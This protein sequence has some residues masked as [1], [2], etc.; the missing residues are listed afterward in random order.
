VVFL[1]SATDPATYRDDVSALLSGQPGARYLLTDGSC[2]SLRQRMPDGRLIY[3]VYLGPFP[4]QATA[5]AVHRR[6]G[7]ESYVKVLDDT[8]APDRLWTC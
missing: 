4:D 2:S 3:A 5:C 1:G 8:T 7:G 6:A